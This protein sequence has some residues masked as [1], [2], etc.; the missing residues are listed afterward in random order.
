M[1]IVQ[2]ILQLTISYIFYCRGEIPGSHHRI[3]E[4]KSLVHCL[5]NM[6]KH[7]SF[8]R[9]WGLHIT[10]KTHT[11]QKVTHYNI[12]IHGFTYNPSPRM[13]FHKPIGELSIWW[14]VIVVYLMLV[15]G[16][17]IKIYLL[18]VYYVAVAKKWDK[19]QCEVCTLLPLARELKKCSIHLYICPHANHMIL[20]LIVFCTYTHCWASD[21]ISSYLYT[22]YTVLSR[23][24]DCNTCYYI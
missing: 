16:E 3:T 21:V 17:P 7:L 24:L 9:N 2:H 12:Y 11:F 6:T 19:R 20:K 23:L 1:E 18:Y 5:Q 10:K 13:L 4:N 22:T 8:E 14:S 15:P